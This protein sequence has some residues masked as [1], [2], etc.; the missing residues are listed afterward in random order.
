MSQGDSLLCSTLTACH[1][2]A[3]D[4]C[5]C[6]GVC[7]C[8]MV[9][10]V[11]VS[12]VSSGVHVQGQES[13]SGKAVRQKLR[14]LGGLIFD[15][16]LASICKLSGSSLADVLLS[17]CISEDLS[18]HRRDAINAP[19]SPKGFSSTSPRQVRTSSPAGQV[20]HRIAEPA[21]M[22]GAAE[23]AW[24]VWGCNP[25][26]QTEASGSF[27]NAG[28]TSSQAQRSSDRHTTE[29][30]ATSWDA[31]RD[32]DQCS[33]VSLSPRVAA[34][35]PLAPAG[36]GNAMQPESQFGDMIRTGAGPSWLESPSP[37]AS[38]TQPSEFGRAKQRPSGNFDACMDGGFPDMETLA[39]PSQPPQEQHA[40]DPAAS[41]VNDDHPG[42]F[43]TI[44]GHHKS[45][46]GTSHELRARQHQQQ[47]Q[48]ASVP[49]DAR[50]QG[51]GSAMGMGW[52]SCYS[53]PQPQGHLQGP[54][55]RPWSAY[56]KMAAP[57][58]PQ[59]NTSPRVLPG[60]PQSPS[61]EISHSA[62]P[63]TEPPAES[64]SHPAAD[65][66][67]H[68][69][70]PPAAYSTHGIAAVSSGVPPGESNA[71]QPRPPTPQSLGAGFGGL[72]MRWA[73]SPSG[74]KG[75]LDITFDAAGDA[76]HD[77]RLGVEPSA[78]S[79]LPAER[80]PELPERS[81]QN[82]QPIS[83]T[84]S[85]H[86][87]NCSH[88]DHFSLRSPTGS[89]NQSPNGGSSAASPHTSAAIVA[90]P[91]RALFPASS[92]Q[93]P[94][95]ATSAAVR[96]PLP[97]SSH[98]KIQTRDS[99]PAPSQPESFSPGRFEVPYGS[100]T[101]AAELAKGSR[102]QGW[103]PLG[104]KLRAQAGDASNASM[105]ASAAQDAGQHNGMGWR[106][107]AGQGAQAVPHEAGNQRQA[108]RPGF[109]WSSTGE[110]GSL[111][112]NQP[113]RSASGHVGNPLFDSRTGSGAEGLP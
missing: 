26:E 18:P 67:T 56:P 21:A 102:D 45:S 100:L 105:D 13:S 111:S 3:H 44:A 68:H 49:K 107:A 57:S 2:D 69:T 84:H 55:P 97:F 71:Q 59:Q 85:G 40:A 15:P 52:G 41:A 88:P 47:Q 51:S 7:V 27:R 77:H 99:R 89:A 48:Q 106:I 29:A 20:K 38:Q 32:A 58:P 12:H 61:L 19:T 31:A 37:L 8:E 64:V 23:P 1:A 81:C 74:R 16:H 80:M 113:K 4:L 10:H 63:G 110:L 108:A 62:N 90:P 14:Q 95:P 70:P 78:S 83:P 109:K 91:A 30:A 66:S 94:A 60:P 24:P 5:M 87:P 36:V 73:R 9:S 6:V 98:S 93:P 35:L 53:Q 79:Q 54:L 39:R 104:Q 103:D 34:A 43:S 50:L 28:P 82:P 76:M 33:E 17:H 65:A 86:Y 112:T 42:S 101:N 96:L 75:G 46:A 25:A 72:H 11:P 92:Q 22:E